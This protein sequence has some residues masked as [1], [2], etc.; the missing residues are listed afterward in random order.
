MLKE[1]IS[2]TPSQSRQK[3]IKNFSCDNY[4][5]KK[6]SKIIYKIREKLVRSNTIS[7]LSTN[8]YNLSRNIKYLLKNKTPYNENLIQI[9]NYPLNSYNEQNYKTIYPHTKDSKITYSTIEETKNKK[10]SKQTYVNIHDFKPSIKG[11]QFFL[12]QVILSSMNPEQEIPRK[13]M[14]IN[15]I[16]KFNIIKKKKESKK[17]LLPMQLGKDYREFI[18][19]KNKLRFNPNFNSPYIHK[20]NSNYMIDNNF[21]NKLKEGF[22]TT[23][24]KARL[25]LNAQIELEK[26]QLEEELRDQMEEMSLELQNYKKAIKLILS[27][28][29]KLNQIYIHEE[30]FDSFVNK[31]N[32]LF[33]DRKFPTIKNKLKKL[34]VEIK[35]SGGYE[36]NRLNMIEISTL[37]YLH[38]LKAKIQ[39][40]LDEI[41]DENKEKQ[42][43]I[44]QQIGKYDY[45]NNKKKK[46]KKN[47]N[48]TKTEESRSIYISNQNNSKTLENVNVEEEEEENEEEENKK[49]NKEDLY[50]FEEFFVHKGRPYKVVDFAKGK[51]AYTVYHNPKFY[52][53]FSKSKASKKEKNIIKRKKEFDLFL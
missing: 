50:E 19:R 52:I 33:D 48:K 28:E 3:L 31:I 6:S 47:L 18:E 53:D 23:K 24:I 16:L 39:R 36:W 37:T 49:E 45:Y 42:F 40:E 15:R 26:K 9:K 30:F 11:C 32:Y 44:N 41:E 17:E 12:P 10:S 51:L 7:L 21:L 13:F 35:A 29:T 22:K 1:K 46:S 27:D 20:M 38:K 2:R 43:K 25:K 4:D 34:I 14:Q 8:N 5:S